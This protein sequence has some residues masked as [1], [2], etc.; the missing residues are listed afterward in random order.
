MVVI[1][2]V[3]IRGIITLRNFPIKALA[4]KEKYSLSSPYATSFAQTAF[5]VI[6][7]PWE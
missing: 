1:V 5:T 3:T 4:V 2:D 6:K 7:S